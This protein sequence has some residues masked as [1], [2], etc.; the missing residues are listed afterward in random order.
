MKKAKYI[1]LL[2]VVLILIAIGLR[3]LIPKA[4][5]AVDK[6]TPLNNFNQKDSIKINGISPAGITYKIK[7][8]KAI[9][10][11]N[12]YAAPVWSP[13]GNSI[14]VTEAG[15]KGLYLI[16]VSNNKVRK[17]ND[18]QGAGYN[19]V[20]SLD[21]KQIYFRNKK[22]NQDYSSKLEVNSI[23]V[24]SGKISIHPEINPDGLLSYFMAKDT[25]SPI[26]YTNTKT[27]LIEAQTF[28]KSKTWVITK[29]PGQYYQAILSPDRTK[30]VLHNRG[31]MFVYSVDGSGLISSLGRGIA[32]S[33]SSDSKQILYFL[34]EDDGHFKTGS[35]LYLCS[36]DGLN[37]WKLTNTPDV[38]EMFPSWSPDNK[39][40]VYSDD[41]SG[42][43]FIAD[44]V[45]Q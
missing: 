6:N 5:N 37:K 38:Y 25:I 3:I 36:S 41:K 31:E 19:A 22:E 1:L 24:N 45:K 28:D 30:I 2:L 15:Y 13:D 34:G 39:K 14:L 33:W 42:K 40:I 43:I 11:E 10:S 17:L 9:T 27:L 8:I 16:D 21:S 35:E 12:Y 18:I 32:C 26:V 20:W 4:E 23:D 7:D 29:D 44:L